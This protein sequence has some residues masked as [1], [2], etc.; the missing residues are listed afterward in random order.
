MNHEAL[1]EVHPQLD[2]QNNASSMPAPAPSDPVMRD[3][4]ARIEHWADLPPRANVLISGET[5]VGKEVVARAIHRLS[6]RA[7]G[8][9][10]VVNCA[11]IAESLFERELFG[12]KKGA[13][14]DAKTDEVGFFEQADGGTLLLDE[15]GELPKALQSKLLR[16]VEERLVFRVGDPK[17]RPIDVRI[18]SAT[19]RHLET[20]VANGTFRSDLFHRLNAIE[21]VVPPLRTRPADIIPLA[22]Y[23][24]DEERR[25]LGLSSAFRL[26]PETI[27][28]LQ[29]YV[30]PGNVREL[31]HALASAILQCRDEVIRPEH[32][33][34]RMNGRAIVSSGQA[35]MDRRALRRAAE[36]E[37]IKWAL[38]ETGGNQTRAASLI[39]MPLRTFV[40]RLDR[41][42]FRRPKKMD[43]HRQRPLA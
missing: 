31:R 29:Q 11:A 41:Y 21:I 33:P 32:L 43:A 15:I 36:F 24:L 10:V 22:R 39:G 3:L 8:P 17:P 14:T 7:R 42:G 23:L 34:R 25:G 4:Y 37:Q 13:F 20:C 12:H 6:K 2:R 19:N 5:G 9:F 35:T 18:I 16:V 30:F 27:A 1:L 38:G 26:A 28:C 40:T